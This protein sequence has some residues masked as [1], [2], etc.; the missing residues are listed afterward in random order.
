MAILPSRSSADPIFEFNT[1]SLGRLGVMNVTAGHMIEI[2]KLLASRNNTS[3]SELTDTFIKALVRT[4]DGKPLTSEQ[5][6][7][8]SNAEK[9]D[10]AGQLVQSETYLYRKQIHRVP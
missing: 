8:L 4:A 7:F 3:P 10:F 6:S 5:I 1:E 2:E 9:E